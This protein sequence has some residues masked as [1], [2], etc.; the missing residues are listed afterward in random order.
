MKQ[1]RQLKNAEIESPKLVCS[2]SNNA[3]TRAKAGWY[4]IVAYL[5]SALLII[6][7]NWLIA[8]CPSLVIV[9]GYAFSCLAV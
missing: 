9:D 2:L 4:G 1:R 3:L 5:F 8:T 7:E 6:V